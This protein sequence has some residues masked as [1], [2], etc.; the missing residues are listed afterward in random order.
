MSSRFTAKNCFDRGGSIPPLQILQ[1]IL[2]AFGACRERTV[3]K[4]NGFILAPP[5]VQGS[6]A[7]QAKCPPSLPV[8]LDSTRN[9]VVLAQRT[10]R[11][12]SN[13]GSIDRVA[14]PLSRKLAGRMS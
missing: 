11:I 14:Q 10:T 9:H 5:A 3:H 13:I 12:R 6:R 8:S 7:T 1:K 4:S 2:V